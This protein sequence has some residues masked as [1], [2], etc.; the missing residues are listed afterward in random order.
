MI[1]EIDS[2]TQQNEV[3]INK[4]RLDS[5]QA[6]LAAAKVS[7]EVAE[8][9][10]KRMQKLKKGNAASDEDLENAL[11]TTVTVHPG[12]LK[13]YKEVGLIS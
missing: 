5:Y 11:D 12:A 2:T 8:K 6:Q 10:Y 7:L 9:Q 1:A 13:Y 4:S 3:D